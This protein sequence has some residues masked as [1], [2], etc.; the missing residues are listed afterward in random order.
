VF[1][2]YSTTRAVDVPH[3]RLQKR[4]MPTHFR[5]LA[6]LENALESK[7]DFRQAVRWYDFFEQRELRDRR[8]GII[9]ASLPALDAVR[10]AISTMIR[11]VSNPRI[12]GTTGRFAVDTKDPKGAAIKL[13]LDQL[14][15]G[16]QVILGV[17]MDFALRLALANPP[18]TPGDDVLAGDAIL[19]IDEVDLHLHPSWQQRVIPDL[20]RTFPN[21]QLILTTHSPQVA[22]TVPS[23]TLRILSGSQLCSAPAGTEGAEAQRLLEDAFLVDARPKLPPALELNEYLRL[24]DDRKWDTDQALA[25]RRHLDEWSQGQE[26]RLL[27]ADLQIE[28]MKWEAGK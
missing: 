15:D 20:R 21:S 19:C 17:V 6:G 14:F 1:A 10:R 13:H 11:E 3:Y 4:G 9:S 5:R 16:Y 12:D 25:L 7:T 26:P 28:N 8:D 2:S 18:E 23:A 24:V 22:T 27:E